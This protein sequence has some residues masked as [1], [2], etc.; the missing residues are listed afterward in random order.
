MADL[1]ARE[2]P[3]RVGDVSGEREWIISRARRGS[4]E[5]GRIVCRWVRVRSLAGEI[6]GV[7]EPLGVPEKDTS[8]ENGGEER[9]IGEESWMGE[10]GRL[11]GKGGGVVDDSWGEDRPD[12]AGD[13]DGDERPG[14]RCSVG[15]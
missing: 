14:V 15:P 2:G 4:R 13:I 11:R 1:T 12:D 10:I 5:R 3:V 6:F 7:G 9:S 8:G